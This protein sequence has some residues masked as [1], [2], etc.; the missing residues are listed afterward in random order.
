MRGR[1]VG[2]L[3]C[4]SDGERSAA[5]YDAMG[6]AYAEHNR[7]GPWNADYER[8]A[9]IA[10]LGD[11]A[12][13]R[14]LDIG[15]GAGV[16][17]EWLV[18]HGASVTAVD[19]S[20]EMVRIASDRLRGRARILVADA[21]RPLSFVPDASLDL[22]VA[23]LFLHYVRD[24]VGVLTADGTAVFST[25]HPSA[26]WKLFSPDNYF[27]MKQVTDTF[28]VDG[29]AFPV[30]FWRRPLTA[31]TAAMSD[32]GFL[33][34]ALVEPDPGPGLRERDP[35]ADLKLRRAPSFLFFRLRPNATAGPSHPA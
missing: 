8:P 12:G 22:V 16:L 11:V 20:P 27:A 33:I 24:W 21:G 29:R 4:V 9:T 13:K 14:I 5:E 35:A 17:T 28:T 34:E 31:M 32:A 2:R 26:D 6:S 3:G 25:H 1:V 30:T 10:L 15:C 23:S 7:D 18:D 19:V